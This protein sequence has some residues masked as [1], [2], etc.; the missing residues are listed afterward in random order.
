MKSLIVTMICTASLFAVSGEVAQ[1]IQTLH[2]ETT[3]TDPAFK[4]FNAKRG[5]VIFTS[6]Y[7]GKKG[8]KI[9][10]TSCHTNDL[11]AKGENFFTGKV[12]EP[13]SALANPERLTSVKEVK[14][15][16]R[17]NFK[18]VYKREGTAQEKGDVLAYIM[19]NRKRNIK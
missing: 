6:E 19:Q 1:Y 16:L 3:Q 14:K 12:I 2:S 13:L 4:D 11:T 7:I 5:Q 17:R 15:W 9:A 18:D 10:C 8:K